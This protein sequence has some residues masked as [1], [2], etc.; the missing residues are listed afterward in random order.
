M[1]PV[2]GLQRA[3]TLGIKGEDD[4]IFFVAAM[5]RVW[6]FRVA[7]IAIAQNDTGAEPRQE[8]VPAN[9]YRR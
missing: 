5:P 4:T 9:V 2:P 7:E 3:D 8:G 1:R 6:Y